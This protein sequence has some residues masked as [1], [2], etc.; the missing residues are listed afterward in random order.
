VV[1]KGVSDFVAVGKQRSVIERKKRV[2]VKID[3]FGWNEK[4]G[5][6]IKGN[7]EGKG[8]E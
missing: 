3:M 2:E 7:E 6:M 1:G 8:K 5:K 4:D